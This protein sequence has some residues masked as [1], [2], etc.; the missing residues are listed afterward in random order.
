MMFPAFITKNNF[1]KLF[2][3]VF[4][5]ILVLISE[6]V[7]I[8][9]RYCV[10]VYNNCNSLRYIFL[11]GCQFN[12]VSFSPGHTKGT[13][14]SDLHPERENWSFYS[15]LGGGH[16]ASV[17]PTTI[18]NPNKAICTIDSKTSEVRSLCLMI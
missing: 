14:S 12:D 9:D 18:R 7:K 15:Y 16:T 3:L 10:T 8:I 6:I 17:F 11:I 2:L 5:Q 4:I 13:L 1:H